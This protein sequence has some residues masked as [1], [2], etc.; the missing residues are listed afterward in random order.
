MKSILSHGAARFALGFLWMLVP[1]S[2]AAAQI[3]PSAGMLRYPDISAEKI[4]FSY[5]DDLWIVDRAGGI[6]SPL[7]SPPGAERFPRFSPDGQTIAFVGNYDDG[8]DLYQISVGGGVPQRLTYHPASE[9]LCDWHADGKT[10]LYS[11]NGF[12]GLGRQT[13]LFTISKNKPV[14]QQLPVPYGSNGAISADGKWLAYTP[15]SRDTRTWKRYRGGMA[16]DVWLFNLENKTS[17]RITEFEGTDTLPMWN[18]TTVY[19]LSDAGAAHRLNIWS[20]DT[21]SGER[22]QIT[23]FKD[24]DCKW[25]AIGPG[26]DGKGEIILSNG[27]DLYVVNLESKQAAAIDV[28]IPGDRPKLRRHKIDAADFITSGDLSPKGKRVVLAARGDLWTLP[29]KNGSPRNISATSDARERY[30]FW[31]S[32]GRWIA[33]FSDATG[34]FELYVTQSDGKGETRQLTKN[35]NC[36]RYSGAWSPDSKHLTFTDKTGA[37]FLYTLESQ[38]T[39]KVDTHPFAESIDANW[40]HD[41]NWL[42][43][44]KGLDARVPTECVWVY[45][46]KDGTKKRLTS[47][48]FNDTDPVFDKKGDHIFFK[49][50]RA[51]NRPSYEDVGTTFVY[52]DTQVMMAMPLRADVPYPMLPKSDEVEW[53]EEKDEK[54]KDESS[55]KKDQKSDKESEDSEDEKSSDK[56]SSTSDAGDLVSGSWSIT[57]DSEQIPEPARSATFELTLGDDGSITGNVTVMGQSSSIQSGSF[58]SD[59]GELT[60]KITTPDGALATITASISGG[61]M[62]GTASTD[63]M[64][65]PFSGTRSASGDSADEEADDSDDD[66]KGKSDDDDDDSEA[67]KKKGKAKEAL[68]IDFDGIEQR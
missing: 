54:D 29:V 18:G 67:S 63:A 28:T 56:D 60:F 30:P 41:S 52:A 19:Y 9:S 13:Q 50:N 26:K 44:S 24:N 61:R 11:T 33:Y 25:P 53:E 17:K 48:F 31:S 40:S 62:E 8:T 1:A 15:Y 39:I 14:P 58:D 12:A 10:L 49:S 5:A 59:S 45:N 37:L 42:C 55:D 47:G 2:Y 32:D 68:K 23:K 46:V 36:F 51:F 34:E 65:I 57:L 20:Y 35:G 64:N 21:L 66:A 4:V 7:A 3:K 16:S 22:Q 38:K 6:A 43:Y 27:P